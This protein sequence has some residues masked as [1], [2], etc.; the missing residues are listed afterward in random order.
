MELYQFI[1]L[2]GLLAAGFAWMITWLRS[3]DGRINEL[4][5]RI[6][7]VEARMNHIEIKVSVIE[8]MLNFG[9]S[10]HSRIKERTDP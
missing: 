1:T 8:T 4:D 5:K 2:I 10:L 7:A 6:T 9:Q 3:I